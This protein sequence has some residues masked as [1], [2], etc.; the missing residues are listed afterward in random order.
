MASI[1]LLSTGKAVRL[2]ARTQQLTTQTSGLAPSYLQAN[3]IIL[4]SRYAADFRLLCARNPV[5]C[6]LLAESMSPG[7][8]GNL[9]TH[10]RHP[11]TNAQLRLADDVDLRHDFPRYRVYERGQLVAEKTDIAAEWAAG[12]SVGFLIGCSF[13]FEAALSAAGLPPRQVLHSR[14]VPMYRTS[15]PLCPA[16]VFRGAYVVSMRPYRP[17]EVER[18][19][20]ITRAFVATHGE[21]IAWGWDGARLLGIRDITEP[22]FG[23]AALRLDRKGLF[24]ESEEPYIPVFWGCGVTP[25]NVVQSSGLEDTII[26]HSPGHMLVCDLRDDEI[27]SSTKAEPIAMHP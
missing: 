8:F 3:L 11:A 21:P 2:A 1:T 6:P 7:D 22:E 19:R 4:P 26:T 5:P 10:L 25:A 20:G 24:D 16:G 23:E 14:N 15:L 13:S 17:E 18:V 12:D 27:F 9:Q